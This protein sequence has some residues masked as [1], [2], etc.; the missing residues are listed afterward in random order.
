MVTR[1]YQGVTHNHNAF[2]LADKSADGGSC[3]LYTSVGGRAHHAVGRYRQDGKYGDKGR[4]EVE[5]YLSLI[6]I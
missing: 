2:P 6:H 5:Y 3:L 4:K 1:L